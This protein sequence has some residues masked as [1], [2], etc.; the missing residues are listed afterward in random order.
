MTPT[1]T[2]ASPTRGDPRVG[3]RAEPSRPCAPRRSLPGAGRASPALPA[4]ITG[5]NRSSA[6]DPAAGPGLPGGERS[7][8]RAS[9]GGAAPAPSAGLAR[10]GPEASLRVTPAPR[11]GSGGRRAAGARGCRGTGLRH[12]RPTRP[13][14][15]EGLGAG[16]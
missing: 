10:R 4:G 1:W 11:L 16:P 12:R 3:S 2:R 14:A 5:A 7:P 13:R 15:G 6:A 8:G 9:G